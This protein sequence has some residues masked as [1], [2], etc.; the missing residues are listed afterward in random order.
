MQGISNYEYEQQCHESQPTEYG[1]QARSMLRASQSCLND[2]LNVRAFRD[3]RY[4][5]ESSL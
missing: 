5:K 1:V 4:A 2:W 3:N